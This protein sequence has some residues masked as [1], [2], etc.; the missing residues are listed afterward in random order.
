[1]EIN[2]YTYK[3]VYLGHS[4]YQL[5]L[6]SFIAKQKDV[7]RHPWALKCLRFIYF[8]TFP[9]ELVY[10]RGYGV[11][12][13]VLTDRHPLFEPVFGSYRA[14]KIY[15]FILN[16]VSPYPD[17]VIYLKGNTKTLWERKKEMP[18]EVYHKRSSELDCIVS[19]VECNMDVVHVDTDRE[20]DVVY[21]EIWSEVFEGKKRD[22]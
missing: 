3:K 12:D 14:R 22:F 19:R 9:L 13:I 11:Y 4:D 21:E 6:V 8:I 16:I 18:F 2:N 17:K 5:G 10:R 20:T 15:S 7:C 1:M